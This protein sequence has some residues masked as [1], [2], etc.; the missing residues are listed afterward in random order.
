MRAI[1]G[2]AERYQTEAERVAELAEQ[3]AIDDMAAARFLRARRRTGKRD[4]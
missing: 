1:E 2:A 4:A 3:G